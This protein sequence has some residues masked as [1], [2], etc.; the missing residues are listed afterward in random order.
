MF[1]S[2]RITIHSLHKFV[3]D[4]FEP[5]PKGHNCYVIKMSKHEQPTE[6][7]QGKYLLLSLQDKQCCNGFN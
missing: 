3:M 1:I 7:K 4:P 2:H 5:K 6:K